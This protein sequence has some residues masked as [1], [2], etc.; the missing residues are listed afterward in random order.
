MQKLGFDGISY[1]A[2]AWK[3]AQASLD[4]GY[5][6]E[7]FLTL[8][9]AIRMWTGNSIYNKITKTLMADTCNYLGR[10]DKDRLTKCL[11]AIKTFNRSSNTFLVDF[12]SKHR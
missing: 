8:R 7:N 12:G 10:K 1:L 11:E 2:E 9:T 3:S 4:E 6:S 5:Y